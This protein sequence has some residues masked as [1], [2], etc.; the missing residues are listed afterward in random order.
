MTICVFC[1]FRIFFRIILYLKYYINFYTYF[2]I[3]IILTYLYIHIVFILFFVLYFNYFSCIM[4]FNIIG[5]NYNAY[6]LTYHLHFL[7]M[8]EENIPFFLV[9]YHHMINYLNKVLPHLFEFLIII[10]LLW[11][12]IK[13][14]FSLQSLKGK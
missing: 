7:S 5:F 1:C 12:I 6:L 13:Y 4:V 14:H 10:N 3:H 11:K 9:S 8:F 2:F